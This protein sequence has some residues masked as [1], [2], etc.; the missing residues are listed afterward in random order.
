MTLIS[1]GTLSPLVLAMGQGK[2]ER[3]RGP[4]L[5]R[6]RTKADNDTA[7]PPKARTLLGTSKRTDR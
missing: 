3:H 1:P 5:L 2:P 7:Q 6:A 4:T